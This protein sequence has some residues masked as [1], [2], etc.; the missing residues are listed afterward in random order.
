MDKRVHFNQLPGIGRVASIPQQLSRPEM[1][2]QFFGNLV[3]K[4]QLADQLSLSPSFINKLMSEEGLPHLKIGRAV[5]FRT[6]EVVA[7]LQQRRRP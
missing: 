6:V 5:R 4:R 2:G 1:G 3:T 7:W